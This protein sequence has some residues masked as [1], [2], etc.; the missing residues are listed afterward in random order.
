M[1]EELN[2]IISQLIK[3]HDSQLDRGEFNEI[4][5]QVETD[6]EIMSQKVESLL[7]DE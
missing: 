4:L 3:L 5:A 7:R 6:L 1:A 2:G